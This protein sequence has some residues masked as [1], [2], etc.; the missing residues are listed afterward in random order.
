MPGPSIFRF[1]ALAT[2]I[3]SVAFA[4]S[5]AGVGRAWVVV[6]IAA[7]FL[8]AVAVEWITLREV[9]ARWRP[10]ERSEA[11][12]RFRAATSARGAGP[13]E[14]RRSRR[15]VRPRPGSGGMETAADAAAPASGATAG[16]STPGGPAP[17]VSDAL[18]TPRGR[19]PS[20]EALAAAD[21][22]PV[23][24][25]ELERKATV[26]EASVPTRDEPPEALVEP[27]APAAA[28]PE[29]EESA[30]REPERVQ[31][32]PEPE[33]PTAETRRDDEDEEALDARRPAPGP[34]QA[35]ATEAA[36]EGEPQPPQRPDR[37]PTP[38]APSRRPMIPPRRPSP[39]RPVPPPPRPRVVQPPSTAGQAPAR[40]PGV[41]RLAERRREPRAW[42]VW[43]LERAAREE[44]RRSPG[45]SDE[46]SYLLLHL[47]Q[48]AEAGG[49]LPPE[50][51]G[52]VRES[53]G[54]L[55]ERLE[56]V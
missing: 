25:E 19:A 31:A 49:N 56:P 40:E 36:E 53:F 14:P 54:S 26:A 46:W 28:A 15:P 32:P 2:F 55:L 43:D 9:D 11:Q 10:F 17:P 50:F 51:D 21:Q 23:A 27:P 16:E 47:R 41:V 48:F 1:V 34:R 45:R 4:L 39:P 30:A 37:G 52:L 22:A 18:T 20:P 44:A 29:D 33:P 12:A 38:A 6:G 42:N 35:D 24:S 13:A 7:A 5:I 3:V 8:S